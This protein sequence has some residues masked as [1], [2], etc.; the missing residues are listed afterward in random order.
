MRR[1]LNPNGWDEIT[2]VKIRIDRIWRNFSTNETWVRIHEEK[3]KLARNRKRCKCCG[4][5][6]KDSGSDIALAFT[7]KGNK[8][9]C[10]KCTDHF[11]E[12]GVEVIVQ[13]INNGETDN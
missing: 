8:I 5:N 11:E 6:F 4:T 9:L 1:E 12:Q 13:E 2:T 7:N 10:Q 3:P